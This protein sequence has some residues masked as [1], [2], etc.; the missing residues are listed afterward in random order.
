MEMKWIKD[1]DT[2]LE[3]LKKHSVRKTRIVCTPGGYLKRIDEKHFIEYP[4]TMV[5]LSAHLKDIDTRIY[6]EQWFDEH[7]DGEYE[8]FTLKRKLENMGIMVFGGEGGRY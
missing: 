6:L 2:F 5:R 8:H 4:G 3:L 1:K 7:E